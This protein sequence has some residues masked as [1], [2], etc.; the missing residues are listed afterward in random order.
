MGAVLE[1]VGDGARASPSAANECDLDLVAAG[2]M[3]RVANRERADGGHR[4]RDCRARDELAARE[5]GRSRLSHGR[6]PV[7]VG[8]R[9]EPDEAVCGHAPGD[10]SVSHNE[11][12]SSSEQ[13][14][15][16]GRR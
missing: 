10:V 2:G 3:G 12:A 11:S 15:C 6:D 13:S 14:G 1:R 16:R 8:R 7:E 5:R 4:G 9:I